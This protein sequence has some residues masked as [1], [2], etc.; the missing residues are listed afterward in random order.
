MLKS[1]NTSIFNTEENKNYL[2]DK[3]SKA[4]QKFGRKGKQQVAFYQL[5]KEYTKL[6]QTEEG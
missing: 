3:K 1:G 2:G 5:C 6:S 4:V